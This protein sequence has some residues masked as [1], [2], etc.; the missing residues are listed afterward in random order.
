MLLTSQRLLLTSPPQFTTLHH[1]RSS[2]D[3]RRTLSSSCYKLWNFT[4]A[5]L[6]T[7]RLGA[8]HGSDAIITTP[9]TANSSVVVD[10]VTVDSLLAVA[11]FLCIVSSAVVTVSYAVKCT[12]PS[13]RSAAAL[14]VIG[15]SGAFAWGMAAML[16]GV[17]IGGWV[18]RR[19]W[20]RICRVEKSRES[21]NLIDRI[22][23]LEEDLKSSVAIVRVLSRQL[24]KLGIRFRLTRKALKEPIAETAAL[25]QKNSEATRVL[26]M[27]ETLLEKEL[28]EIQK[29]LF[30]MQEQQQKQLELILAIA[31]SGKLWDTKQEHNSEQDAFRQYDAMKSSQWLSSFQTLQ[32]PIFVEFSDVILLHFLDDNSN[33]IQSASA[34]WKEGC[35]RRRPHSSDGIRTVYCLRA[36]AMEE[37]RKLEQVQMMLNFAES[38]GLAS[39]SDNDSKLFISRFILFL[40]S[41]SIFQEASSLLMKSD[42]QVQMEIKHSKGNQEGRMDEVF[43]PVSDGKGSESLMSLD[44]VAVIQLD[45]M[46]RANSTLEDFC[47]SYFMFHEIDVSK[48]ELLFKYLPFLSFTESYVYQIDSWNEKIVNVENTKI[49]CSGRRSEA[50]CASTGISWPSH[51]EIHVEEVMRAIHL[52]SFDY[53]ILNLLLY[54]LCREPDD[55]LENSFN[56]LRMFVNI[57]GPSSAP[58]MLAKCISEAE[59]KYERLLEKIEPHLS[60][61]YKRRCEEATRE[62]YTLASLAEPFESEYKAITSWRQSE[63]K[64]SLGSDRPS[65]AVASTP[66]GHS[67]LIGA[68]ARF[69][70]VHVEAL[71]ILLQGLCGVHRE[72]LNVHELCLKSGPNLGPVTSE[73]RLLCDLEQPEPTWTV[74]HIG[75]AMRGAGADQISVLVRSM[76][77]S[78]ASKNVI[79]FFYALG[80]KLESELLKVGFAF[81]F[82]RGAQITVTVS[83]ISK[84]QKLHAI[85]DA[86][87]VTPGIQL[88]EVTAPATPENYS[89]VVAAVSSFCEYLAPLL[90]LSKPGVSTGVVPTAAA[91]AAS[92]MSDGGGTTL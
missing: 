31:K 92:L 32:R 22:E 91:A 10:G 7:L 58:A 81:H 38:R 80:Y 87:A 44:G 68:A 15:S 24:E 83:S 76:V 77:E 55:V 30:A 12:V 8:S 40:F 25:A 6:R 36:S 90:H 74:R 16:A 14:A 19:Q 59:E 69:L 75:G 43:L 78:K 3:L 34:L 53:R 13:C 66:G 21:V 52:K 47:R 49:T 79:R 84:M 61:S 64:A 27:Q 65:S 54:Q 18:R 46:Q 82:Q 45:A 89:E 1:H 29:L 86:V 35:G 70:R 48:P 33:Y 57:Y 17:V 26:A 23:K 56:I 60:A 85:D 71:E 88:V 4:P 72:P 39:D 37:L 5:R 9:T 67:V 62:G 50:S 11:E 2:P 41:D 63:Y 51:R 73:V 28:A 42:S 20:S